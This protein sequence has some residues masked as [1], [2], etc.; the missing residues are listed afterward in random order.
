MKFAMLLACVCAAT[1][2]SAL[3]MAADER[4]DGD[5]QS[6][7]GNEAGQARNDKSLKFKMI[8]CP[9]GSLVTDQ[10]DDPAATTTLTHGYW[11]GAFEVSRGQWVQIM[12][13]KPWESARFVR[14]GDRMPATHVNWL[15]VMAFCA[16]LTERERSAGRLPDDWQY[17]L[18]T[19][20][21]WEYACR[22]HTTTLFHFGDDPVQLDEYAWYAH[23]GEQRTALKEPLIGD[24]HPSGE[25]KA[26]PWG[27]YD[28]HG[29]VWEWCRDAYSEKQALG[30]DP[31]NKSG[32]SGRV[33]RGGSAW[34]GAMDCRSDRRDQQPAEYG[35]FTIGFRVALCP[36]RKG[37]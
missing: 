29:N 10:A 37:E 31:E 6:L 23:I 4:K 27:L 3:G 24:A 15:D 19:E 7:L 34:S 36:V 21:Q 2:G 17:T 11:L 32:D 8:W 14:G 9:P 18:P 33:I 5:R 35:N 16:K 12:D 1:V 25:K 30:R 20:A 28:M 13:T 26:N 22:A